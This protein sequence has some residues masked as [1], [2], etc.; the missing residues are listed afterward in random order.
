MVKGSNSKVAKV[1]KSKSSSANSSASYPVDPSVICSPPAGRNGAMKKKNSAFILKPV[2]QVAYKKY[3]NEIKQISALVLLNCGLGLQ[4]SK[5]S[6][7]KMQE[8]YLVKNM[9][10]VYSKLSKDVIIGRRVS[11]IPFKFLMI[12]TSKATELT[13]GYTLRKRYS[14]MRSYINN[15][16]S[17]IWRK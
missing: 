8:D 16:L 5:F 1:A 2:E 4:E 3:I 15:T 12:P 13:S 17:P 11:N 7:Q 9:E 6:S 10:K 14:T